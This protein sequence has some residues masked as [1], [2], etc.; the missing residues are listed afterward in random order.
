MRFKECPRPFKYDEYYPE[1]TML[2][3]TRPKAA[4]EYT[5]CFSF[6]GK[7]ILKGERH[8]KVAIVD[9]NGKFYCDRSHLRHED[10]M[11]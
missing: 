11:P 8:L 6:C 4:K 1:Y 2:S 5:C 10:G 9:S 3:R 7:P